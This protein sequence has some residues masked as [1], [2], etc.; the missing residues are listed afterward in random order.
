M[1]M[2]NEIYVSTDIE[3]MG[4]IPGPYS[5]LSLGSVAFSEDGKLID[6]FYVNLLPLEESTEHPD[7]KKWWETQPEAWKALQNDRKDPAEAMKEYVKWVN[8]LKGIP[9]FMAYP[10]GFDWTFVYWYMIKFVGHSPF[11]FSA[12]DIKTY[13]MAKLNCPYRKATKKNFPKRWFDK[14]TPHDHN[15]LNDAHGQG[16]MFFN[17]LKDR[18]RLC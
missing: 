1:L 18:G 13:A 12:L 10:A 17:M 14:Q 3:T 6:T 7:T 15:A 4:P 11:S 5:M 16:I 9:V 8:Q 2:N